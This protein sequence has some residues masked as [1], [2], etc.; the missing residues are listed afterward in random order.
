VLEAPTAVR[1]RLDGHPDR[2][3]SSHFRDVDGRVKSMAIEILVYGAIG[4]LLP[5]LV[6]IAK[7][8]GEMSVVG[9]ANILISMVVLAA[10][11][12]VAAFLTD[13]VTEG[14]PTVI[15]AVTAGFTGP[16][17]ISR[18]VGGGGGGREATRTQPRSVTGWWQV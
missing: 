6:R 11:G 1:S 13:T 16:E 17:V 9:G 4:G 7:A 15:S 18:L 10:L 5:D 8:K 12:A 14:L 3:L 2:T